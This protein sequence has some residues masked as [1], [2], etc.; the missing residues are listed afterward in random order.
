MN[1]FDVPAEL[2]KK[3]PKTLLFLLWILKQTIYDISG[4][5]LTHITFERINKHGQ[6]VESCN[7]EQLVQKVRNKPTYHQIGNLLFNPDYAQLLQTKPP[8]LKKVQLFFCM[9]SSHSFQT[10]EFIITGTWIPLDNNL[11]ITIPKRCPAHPNKSQV[12]LAD[13]RSRLVFSITNDAIQICIWNRHFHSFLEMLDHNNKIVVPLTHIC[14]KNILINQ[15]LHKTHDLNIPILECLS[16]TEPHF[17][18]MLKYN[19][20]L[21]LAMYSYLI[22]FEAVPL[23]RTAIPV[24]PYWVSNCD[25][26]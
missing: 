24:P 21:G 23:P 19:Q 8:L 17:K 14:M 25:L 22:Q 7:L 1:R 9:C 3:I 26:D 12:L 2:Q 20:H 18:Q 13:L 6:I 10:L 11:L 16:K 5:F 4:N 15:L